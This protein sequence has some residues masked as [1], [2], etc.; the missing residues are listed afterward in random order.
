MP[1]RPASA[2]QWREATGEELTLTTHDRQLALAA[3]ASGLPVLGV[4]L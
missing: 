3:R 2:L 1:I 4:E